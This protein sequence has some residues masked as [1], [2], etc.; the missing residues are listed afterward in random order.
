[1][2]K[3]YDMHMHVF[4][5]SHPNL[6]AFIKR[7]GLLDPA[8]ISEFL[9][10][11]VIENKRDIF[12][13]W[14]GASIGKRRLL[15]EIESAV[16]NI[17]EK[18]SVFNKVINLLSIM[19]NPIEYQFLILEYF[20]KNKKPIV[21]DKN[22][23]KVDNEIYNKI[24]LCPL[25]MDFGNKNINNDKVFY[26][27]SP[28]KPI[29][30]QVEDVLNAIRIY[31][32]GTLGPDDK[33]NLRIKNGDS[34]ESDNKLFEIYPFMGLNT[35]NYSLKELEELFDKF[36]DGYE[37]DTTEQRKQKL[38]NNFGKFDGNLDKK[39]LPYFFVGIKV[40]P[41]LGF[42]PWP[43]DKNKLQKV[44]L[45]YKTAIKKKI[46]VITHCSDGGY[47]TVGTKESAWKLTDP[48]EKWTQ[49]L[50]FSDNQSDFS[51]LKLCFAHF[52]SEST[53]KKGRKSWSEKIID[54]IE[55]YDNVYTDISCC[56]GTPL[57]YRNLN[58]L[59]DRS[60]PKL[61]HRI[62]YGSDFSINL[63]AND[64][65]Q[66]YNH[67]TEKFIRNNKGAT[68]HLLCARNPEKFLFDTGVF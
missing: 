62:M 4:D 37:N 10:N 59:I 1:M 60:T 9:F 6:L 33:G 47:N 32:S 45:L 46:P 11:A 67:T 21:S 19:E 30:K 61:K 42:D 43:A 52:G 25:L 17:F 66:S 48:G 16:E 7:D 51:K 36:F 35:E 56:S 23:L 22:E 14:L 63:L 27:K 64:D 26:D 68:K 34:N 38:K 3:F 15:S 54:L 18:G 8:T 24:V 41:P 5:L 20:L 49:A 57:Y 40:Y 55:K 31:N 44:K 53:K 50:A 29:S 65:E 12:R 2:K 39:K 58:S 28:K 13:A